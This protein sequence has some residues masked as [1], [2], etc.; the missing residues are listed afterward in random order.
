MAKI[1][2]D[3]ME[4]Y[5]AIPE[6]VSNVITDAKAYL[7]ENYFPAYDADLLVKDAVIIFIDFGDMKIAD[8]VEFTIIPA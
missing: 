1:T 4:L 5:D 7:E 2:V 6:N 3:L 8:Y